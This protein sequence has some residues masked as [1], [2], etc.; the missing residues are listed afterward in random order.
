[1]IKQTM[2]VALAVVSMSAFAQ[3]HRWHDQDRD[4]MTSAGNT[5]FGMHKFMLKQDENL[6]GP[7]RYTFEAMLNR[8]PANEENALIKGLWNAH[9]Q[10][11]V[12]REQMIASRFPD[13]TE[14]GYAS[15]VNTSDESS[16]PMR[17][18]MESHGPRDIDYNTAENILS[19]SLTDTEAN[20]LQGWWTQSTEAQKD[21]VVRL[22]KCSAAKA[23]EPIYSSLYTHPTYEWISTT[24]TTTTI[25]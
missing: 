5:E 11:V 6:Q 2:I 25:K 7:D 4:E 24:T 22:L 19:A 17:M 16:R 15:N 23:D 21:V 1:M 13:A 14:E 10:A 9:H 3:N 20:W 18:V 12:V 8:M